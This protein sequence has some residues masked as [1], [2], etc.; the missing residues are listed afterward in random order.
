MSQPYY[1]YHG[2][3]LRIDLT[4]QSFEQEALSIEDL[5]LFWGGRGLGA[6]YLFRELSPK[7]DPLSPENPLIFSTGP[8]CSTGVFLRQGQARDN[9]SRI[10]RR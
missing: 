3:L 2:K 8:F 5:K 9:E 7:T 6:A 10:S 1:G 4:H